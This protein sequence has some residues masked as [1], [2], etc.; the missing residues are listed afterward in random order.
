M[1]KNEAVQQGMNLEKENDLLKQQY[2]IQEK[3]TELVKREDEVYRTVSENEKELSHRALKLAKVGK[4]KSNWGLQRL[5][6][7]PLLS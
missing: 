3:V 5:P 1:V 7:W 6:D 4:P 2:V